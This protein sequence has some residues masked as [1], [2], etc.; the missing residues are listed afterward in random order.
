MPF[1]GFHFIRADFEKL[2]TARTRLPRHHSQPELSRYVGVPVIW[3]LECGNAQ[4]MVSAIIFQTPFSRT[5]NS[6]LTPALVKR[7]ERYSCLNVIT[8][9]FS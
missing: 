7:L 6:R 3:R 9:Y 5:V 4:R 2:G 1:P 8:A